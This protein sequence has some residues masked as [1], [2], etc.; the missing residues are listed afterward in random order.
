MTDV[1]PEIAALHDL[2]FDV[3]EEGWE[4]CSATSCVSV[5]HAEAAVLACEQRM[6]E[7]IPADCCVCGSCGHAQAEPNW[8][9]KCGHRTVPA[10]WVALHDA[11][12]RRHTIAEIVEELRAEFQRFSERWHSV[13]TAA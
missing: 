13:R 5:E 9:H 3:T 4:S 8:C 11:A 12:V 1:P 6:S 10:P 7:C 2:A